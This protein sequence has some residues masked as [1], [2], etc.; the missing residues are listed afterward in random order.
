M[1]ISKTVNQN[2]VPN[3]GLKHMKQMQ[4]TTV[5]I[6]WNLPIKVRAAKSLFTN[7]TTT[8]TYKHLIKQKPLVLHGIGKT[9]TE[10]GWS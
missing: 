1:K 2:Y 5:R 4:E 7:A 9:I 10:K 8:V 3:C 6:N